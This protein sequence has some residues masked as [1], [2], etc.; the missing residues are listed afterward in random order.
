[1]LTSVRG[2]FKIRRH[3]G[4]AGTILKEGG[5][6]NQQDEEWFHNLGKGI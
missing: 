4:A 3:R 6:E 2:P 1:M 5:V